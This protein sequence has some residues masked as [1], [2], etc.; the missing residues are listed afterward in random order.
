MIFKLL[1]YQRSLS[2]FPYSLYS[3]QAAPFVSCSFLIS[4]SDMCLAIAGSR[5][6]TLLL[7]SLFVNCFTLRMRRLLNRVY[8]LLQMLYVLRIQLQIIVVFS[9]LIQRGSYFSFKDRTFTPHETNSQH[10]LMF[11]A[12]TCKP[13]IKNKTTL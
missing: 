6:S 9:P 4:L 2:L 8:K 12:N 3:A 1:S 13:R 11:L 5:K 10:Q 7:T